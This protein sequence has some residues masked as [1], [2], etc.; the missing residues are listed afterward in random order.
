MKVYVVIDAQNCW[1]T[2]DIWVFHD[3][4][5][6]RAQLSVKLIGTTSE[7]VSDPNNKIIDVFIKQSTKNPKLWYVCLGYEDS[8]GLIQTGEE[9]YKQQEQ[10]ALRLDAIDSDYIIQEVEV[11]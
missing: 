8:T 4:S 2:G 3:F 10:S 1:G 7:H 5:K 11:E 9:W 6:I